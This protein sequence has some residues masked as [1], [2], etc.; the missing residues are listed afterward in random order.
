M[1]LKD[2]FIKKQSFASIAQYLN[3]PLID[4]DS[5]KVTQPWQWE[6]GMEGYVGY[7]ESRGG[8]AYT[9]WNGQQA[10]IREVFAQQITKEMVDYFEAFWVEHIGYF[11]RPGWD[12][13][14]NNCNGYIPITIHSAH[15]GSII[16]AKNVL[17]TVVCEDPIFGPCT[18]HLETLLLRVWSPSTVGTISYMAKEMIYEGMLTSCDNLDK[19]PFMLHD[20]GARGVSSPQSAAINGCAHLINFMGS[21]TGLGLLGARLWYDCQMAG[22]S[23][24]ASEHS[25]ITSWGLDTEGETA[26]FRNMIAKFG[27]SPIFACVSD[28]NDIA[29]AC[30]QIWGDVLKDEVLDMNAMLVIRPDSGDPIVWL[31]KL[32]RILDHRFGSTV[33]TKGFKVLNKVRLIQGDGVDIETLPLMIKAILMAGFSLD[34]VAFG[35]GGGLLQKNNRDTG[36]WAMKC[37]AIKVNG[38]WKEVFKD[39]A[40]DP[41]KKSKK[42]VPLLCKDKNGNF[43]TFTALP[44]TDE[45]AYLS[46]IDNVS[47]QALAQGLKLVMHT[48]YEHEAG[49]DAPFIKSMVF[50][51]IRAIAGAKFAVKQEEAVI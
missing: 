45:Y 46:A 43:V 51:E 35:M 1:N 18:S 32:L 40:T 10:T 38:V 22:Y 3:N 17:S 39:P 16:P 4:T 30:G 49:D 23:I 26:A 11:Y 25:T 42:G 8:L 9:L 37:S 20:F 13:V 31:P 34:N 28:G 29:K 15:E 50:E 27:K 33:N 5:Y 7:I 41:G 21:D 36:K 48:V 6:E 2:T 19:L 24:P 44:T 12:H 47:M 14:V